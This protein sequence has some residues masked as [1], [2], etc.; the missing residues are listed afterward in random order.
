MRYINRRFTYLLTYG[1]STMTRIIDMPGDLQP[2]SCGWL[3]CVH[4]TRRERGH[5]VAAPL[6]AAQLVYNLCAVLVLSDNC[7]F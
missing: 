2:E 6:Q 4:T 5:I 1:W 7:T 3:F